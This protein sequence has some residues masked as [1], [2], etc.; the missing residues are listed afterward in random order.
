MLLGPSQ[1]LQLLLL[2]RDERVQVEEELVWRV[3]CERHRL[4]HSAVALD[5]GCL[6]HD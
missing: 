1:G 3:F 6:R 5:K 2:L 4:D